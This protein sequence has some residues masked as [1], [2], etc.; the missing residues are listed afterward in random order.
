MNIL[1]EI[2]QKIREEAYKITAHANEEM[3]KDGLIAIDIEN[4]ILTGQ[5]GKDLQKTHAGCD[6]K[7]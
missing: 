4:A 5:I 7:L 6:M 1:D 3:S 2:R